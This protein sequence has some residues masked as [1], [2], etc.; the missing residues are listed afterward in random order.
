LAIKIFGADADQL[1]TLADQTASKIENVPGILH[2][3]AEHLA[4]QPQVQMRVNRQAVARYGLP[5]AMSMH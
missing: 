1:Q 4:G 5:W 2:L 3:T